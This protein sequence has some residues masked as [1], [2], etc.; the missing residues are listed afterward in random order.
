MPLTPAKEALCMSIVKRGVFGVGDFLLL[1]KS[2]K[3]LAV[4]FIEKIGI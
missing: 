1:L 3:E 2:H 4:N